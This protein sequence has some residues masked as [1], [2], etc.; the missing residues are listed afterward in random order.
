MYEYFILCIHKK[1]KYIFKGQK[2]FVYLK[3]INKK[4]N[5]KNMQEFLY[6]LSCYKNLRHYYNIFSSE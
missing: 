3:K 6:V 4:Q 1:Y 5:K 2:L